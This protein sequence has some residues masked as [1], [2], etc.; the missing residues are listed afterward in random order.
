MQDRYVTTIF[1]TVFPAVV[2]TAVI[3]AVSVQEA[4]APVPTT[5]LRAMTARFAPAEIGADLGALPP[6]ER[7][8]LAKLVEAARVMDGLFLRQV[9]AGN[10]ALLQRL[11]RDAVAGA[12]P[13]QRSE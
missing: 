12:T 2:L 1:L 5:E 6:N 13:A 11:S 7:Q 3:G 9:W 4:A 10:D 8:A